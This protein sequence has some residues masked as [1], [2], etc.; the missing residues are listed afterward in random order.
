MDGDDRRLSTSTLCTRED[1]GNNVFQVSIRSPYDAVIVNASLRKC[2]EEY[3][4]RISDFRRAHRAKQ[5]HTMLLSSGDENYSMWLQTSEGVA[6]LGIEC[7]AGT[8]STTLLDCVVH[9]LACR[10]Q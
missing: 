6:R 5:P 9:D 10:G 4:A 8:L 1:T 2:H 3:P 7:V